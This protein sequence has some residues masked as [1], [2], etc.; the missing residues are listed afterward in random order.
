MTEVRKN[1]GSY[2][3]TPTNPIPRGTKTIQ[4]NSRNSNSTANYSVI[5]AK[6][7]QNKQEMDYV[8]VE[9]KRIE[10]EMYN[11]QQYQ[12]HNNSSSING[13]YDNSYHSKQQ[14]DKI[15]DQVIQKYTEGNELM[16][17]II[18][19]L[20]QQIKQKVEKQRKINT[21]MTHRD[22]GQVHPDVQDKNTQLIRL[23][24]QNNKQKL[25]ISSL[26]QKIESVVSSGVKTEMDNKLAD[27]KRE[28]KQLKANKRNQEDFNQVQLN[29][30]QSLTEDT[31]YAGQMKRI[32]SQI[33]QLKTQHK[34]F[35]DY[36]QQED[37]KFK[38]HFEALSRAEEQRFKL[39]EQIIQVKNSMKPTSSNDNHVLQSHR[40]Q[41]PSDLQLPKLMRVSSQSRFMKKADQEL[42]GVAALQ[43]GK[44]SIQKKY[45]IQ[46][47]RID[48]EIEGLQKEIE[49]LEIEIIKK[50]D[51]NTDI[52]EMIKE[53]TKRMKEGQSSQQQQLQSLSNHNQSNN[54]TQ[55]KKGQYDQP[56]NQ[57]Y[58]DE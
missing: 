12:N 25:Q 53:Q 5:N 49:C 26:K 55:Y 16:V 35:S 28:I 10:E 43:N 41:Q 40:G 57:Q 23:Q 24:G 39:R 54:N 6:N 3:H 21:V 13:D 9:M 58:Q 15:K 48:Q 34:H 51:E 19:E 38:V 32:Q 27:L 4:D 44:S 36:R 31:D 8:D 2:L 46:K 22:I 20:E 33:E 7:K 14:N 37:S 17:K 45:R 52:H 47:K 42:K 50:N 30:Y 1:A 56:I 11:H 18:A 29:A